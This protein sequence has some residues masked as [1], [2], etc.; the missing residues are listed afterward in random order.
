ME[1]DAASVPMPGDS[2]DSELAED[3]GVNTANGVQEEEPEDPWSQAL[4]GRSPGPAQPDPGEFARFREFL[5]S[6]PNGRSWRTRRER[7]DGEDDETGGQDRSNAGP[8]PAWDGSSSFKDYKIR[9][10]LWLAT[11]KTRPKARGPLLL[12][13][14]SGVA[15]DNLKHLATDNSWMNDVRN[16]EILLETMDT[17]EMFGDDEREDLVNSLIKITYTIG[18]EKNE[19]HREFFSRWDIATRKV[20]DHKVKLPEEYVG[21]LLMMSLQLTGDQ[22]KLLL[23]YTQGSMK[24]RS[25]KEWLRVHE[26]EFDWK[27]NSRAAP[28]GLAVNYVDEQPYDQIGE[29][30]LEVLMGALDELSEDGNPDEDPDEVFDEEDAKEILSAMARDQSKGGYNFKEKFKRTFTAVNAAKKSRSLARGYGV[31]R[32]AGSE[33]R[34]SGP[35]VREGGSY[36]ISIEALKKKTRC[37]S[38]GQ[39]GHWHKECPKKAGSSSG[40]RPSTSSTTTKELNYLNETTDEAYFIDY[41]E[42]LNYKEQNVSRRENGGA[43][44]QR[45]IH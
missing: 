21:F 18:R 42:Y 17:R 38:C 6:Q 33:R 37:A 44:L 13:N 25:I 8:P 28:K 40:A 20:G 14:L 36:K 32:D 1:H 24:P 30:G 15:F 41:M 34:A 35:A 31:N 27:T 39:V 23:N 26:T 5:R 22:I 2:V 11:T 45:S 7:S 19:T 29:D 4:G 10:R 12:K 9:A 16:G 43:R 3:D